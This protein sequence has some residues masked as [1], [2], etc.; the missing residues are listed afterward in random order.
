MLQK[1]SKCLLERNGVNTHMTSHNIAASNAAFPVVDSQHLNKA[2][3]K[4]MDESILPDGWFKLAGDEN[5]F[6]LTVASITQ[7]H[8]F[9]QAAALRCYADKHLLV[10]TRSHQQL[11]NI[12]MWSNK[13]SSEHRFDVAQVWSLQSPSSY[14]TQYGFRRALLGEPQDTPVPELCCKKYSSLKFFNYGCSDKCKLAVAMDARDILKFLLSDFARKGQ[15]DEIFEIP[16][17]KLPAAAACA[18]EPACEIGNDKTAGRSI[19]AALSCVKHEPNVQH[20]QEK[21]VLQSPTVPLAHSGSRLYCV[22]ITSCMH[23]MHEVQE[24][25]KLAAEIDAGTDHSKRRKLLHC[26]ATSVSRV[27]F[28]ANKLAMDSVL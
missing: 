19:A 17:S 21:N 27:F 22:F 4:Q 2:D 8:S 9:L 10:R 11:Q 13:K 25:L 20:Q 24:N 3:G 1:K 18:V 15:Y 16:N 26:A 14:T 7:V 23:R 6:I 28:D 5:D 12:R